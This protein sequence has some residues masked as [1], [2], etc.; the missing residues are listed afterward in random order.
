MSNKCLQQKINEHGIVK[1]H[2]IVRHSV[3]E[4]IRIMV[5]YAIILFKMVKHILIPSIISCF[6]ICTILILF[7]Y[8]MY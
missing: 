1:E 4:Q 3:T 7:L 8:I 5:N 6:T 2:R